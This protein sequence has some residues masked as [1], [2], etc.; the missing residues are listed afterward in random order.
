M[1]ETA[2]VG[3]DAAEVKPKD[4]VLTEGDIAARILAMERAQTVG[5]ID[6]RPWVREVDFTELNR[7]R[8]LAEKIRAKNAPKPEQV[9]AAQRLVSNVIPVNLEAALKGKTVAQPLPPD[10]AKIIVDSSN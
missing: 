10:A 4:E 6:G 1:D 3:T 5:F 7:L 9:A 8:Q 2:L